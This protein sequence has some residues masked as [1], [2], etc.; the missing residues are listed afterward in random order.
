MTHKLWLPRATSALAAFCLP[1]CAVPG[2]RAE[3][4][5]TY[6][7]A[8][9]PTPSIGGSDS[10]WVFQNGAAKRLSASG[11]A[12][13]LGVVLPTIE[14]GFAA[15]YYPS[16]PCPSALSC[17]S[18][19]TD[20]GYAQWRDGHWSYFAA[21]APRVTDQGVLVE[22]PSE[23]LALWSRD[24]TN[25]AWVKTNATAALTAVGADNSANAATQITATAADGT[26]CQTITAVNATWGEFVYSA[27][28]KRITGSGEVDISLNLASGQTSPEWLPITSGEGPLSS[29]YQRYSIAYSVVVNPQFCVR[30]RTSGDAVA[31]DFNQVQRQVGAT[32][33]IVT[34]GS[35][36]TRNGDIVWLTGAVDTALNSGAQ[37]IVLTT[38]GLSAWQ[39]RHQS[40]TIGGSPSFSSSNGELYGWQY[41]GNAIFESNSTAGMAGNLPFALCG[42]T[43]SYDL[44]QSLALTN[45]LGFAWD[46][47]SGVLMDCD[48]GGTLVGSAAA[49][50][51]AFYIGNGTEAAY[52]YLQDVKLYPTKLSAAT[53]QTVTAYSQNKAKITDQ[54]PDAGHW[55]NFTPS[56]GYPLT[57]GGLS[58]AFTGGSLQHDY[59]IESGPNSSGVTSPVQVGPVD[60]MMRFN[61]FANNC[62]VTDVC[63]IGGTGGSERS[64]MDGA[65]GAGGNA[66]WTGTQ[67]VWISYSMCTEPGAPITSNWFITGQIQRSYAPAS[68]NGS[69]P[70]L[71]GG[72]I[73]E[74]RQIGIV[75]DGDSASVTGYT[76]PIIRGAWENFV[77]D[78][79]MDPTGA[80]GKVDIWKN[81]VQIVNFSG[82][83]GI[84]PAA[85]GL[86]NY[87]WKF[88]L[89]R[90][91]APEYEA[92]RYANMTFTNDGTSLASKIAAPDPIP[93]NYGT[94]CQ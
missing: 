70:F 3:G 28:V 35:P 48:G 23:N 54:V 51:G 13:S 92:V 4:F 67:E 40:N 60:N 55:N 79:I 81:G 71:I 7:Q 84:A 11:L 17:L 65:I 63:D 21:N 1:L 38:G 49:P 20:A 57:I 56:V 8:L 6:Q 42:A 9:P 2:A 66:Q 45:V 41:T 72:K 37:T 24:M 19:I 46:A 68:G 78:L 58:P 30:V 12:Q 80:T 75:D 59:G 76:W 32:S 25:A 22:G 93:A 16:Q 18:A 64:E 89:Y 77:L 52:Y 44:Q 82:K 73:G 83:T 39:F 69:P 31:V 14:L 10:F 86:N 88:G 90:S 87:Y 94:T 74:F 36:L 50:S 33:P 15:G 5:S 34:Q 47:A 43:S 61:L 53:L 85:G 27:F 29:A 62:W 91:Q 26:V